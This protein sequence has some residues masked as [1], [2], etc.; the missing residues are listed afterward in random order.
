[1]KQDDF[2]GN[3]EAKNTIS[4]GQKKQ[5]RAWFVWQNMGMGVKTAFAGRER[6][7][8]TST[9]YKIEGMQHD[10]HFKSGRQPQ[11]SWVKRI[12]DS[13]IQ[14]DFYGK[15]WRQP[16]G[17]MGS[18][19]FWDVLPSL[20]LRCHNTSCE[21]LF[22]FWYSTSKQVLQLDSILTC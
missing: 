6:V 3:K 13:G 19:P 8:T 10:L 16:Q 12:E 15:R 22:S 11:D 20:V 14:Q 21:L 5:N 1:M 9:E 7:K 18:F 2:Y 4:L 17:D